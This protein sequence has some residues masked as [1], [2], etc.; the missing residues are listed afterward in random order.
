MVDEE[1]H[2]SGSSAFISAQ[3]SCANS[4]GLLESAFWLYLREDIWAALENRR[5]MKADL[6]SCRVE[7]DF[8]SRHHHDCKWANWMVYI[9]AETVMFSF[10]KIYRDEVT[11]M[12]DWERIWNRTDEWQRKKPASFDPVFAQDRDVSEGRY[13]PHIYHSQIWHGKGAAFAFNIFF[14]RQQLLIFSSRWMAI[15]PSC[16]NHAPR[17]QA[18]SS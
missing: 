11:T 17:T 13:F 1:R 14:F 8:D 2:L 3:Q 18:R 6:W 15:L 16:Q 10:D 5:V 7:I 12:A 4:G 9:V